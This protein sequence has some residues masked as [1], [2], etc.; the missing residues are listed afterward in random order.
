M[1]DA[2]TSTTPINTTS[3]TSDARLAIWRKKLPKNPLPIN[4]STA[5]KLANLLNDENCDSEQLAQQI[6]QDPILCLKLFHCTEMALKERDGDIQHLIHLIGLIG[7]NKVEHV[8]NVSKR[9]KKHPQGLQEVL[10]ASLFAAHL[11]STLLTKKHSG[12]HDRL[13]LPTLFFNSPLWL[14]WIAAPKTMEQGQRLASQE[15][16]SYIDLSVKKLGFHL[17]DLLSHADDFIHLPNVTLKALAIN[18]QDDIHFWAKV[19][20]LRDTKLSHW[21]NQDKPSRHFFYSLEMGIYL[22]NQ[23][24]MAVYLD[25]NGKHIQRYTELL[26]RHLRIE[27]VEL[28]QRVMATAIDV[29]LPN[30]FKGALAPINRINGV[31]READIPHTATIPSL[32]HWTTKIQACRD[33][34]QALSQ[35]LE[36]LCEGIGVDHCVIMEVDDID[37]HTQNCY[38]FEQNASINAFHCDRDKKKHLFNQLLQQPACISLASAD[39]PKAKR[40]IPSQFTEH[41]DLQPCAFLSIFHHEKPKA[42]IYCDHLNWDKEKHQQFKIVGQSL[43]KTLQLL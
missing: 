13:F 38:G 35:T 43:S 20:R 28:H 23:Y 18:P 10:S 37:I 42:I 32:H 27:A 9:S 2:Q 30:P 4:Q 8:I 21:F 14:M 33:I 5:S 22:L 39:I 41:C 26:C 24:V 16:Q 19:H 6:K 17:P 36:A 25:W 11:S 40:R 1:A 34:E 29:K 15:Q 7:F 3:Q 31:H 12:H